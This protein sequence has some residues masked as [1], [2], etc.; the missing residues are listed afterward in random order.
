MSAER[1]SRVSINT[2]TLFIKF[3]GKDDVKIE[4]KQLDID[5]LASSNK[6]ANASSR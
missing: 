1:E 5:E 3:S 6:I 2:S 4:I